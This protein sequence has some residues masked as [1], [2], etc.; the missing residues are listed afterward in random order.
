MY[1]ET[2]TSRS[3]PRETADG[4]AA[5]DARLPLLAL[6]RYQHQ[7]GRDMRSAAQA[8]RPVLQGDVQVSPVDLWRAEVRELE[9]A[10]RSV[11]H[12]GPDEMEAFQ[13]YMDGTKA[14][15]AKLN[16]ADPE[17]AGRMFAENMQAVSSLSR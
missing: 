6:L 17:T 8:R 4:Q 2:V 10:Y 3:A 1:R 9:S 14:A 13:A 12:R 5:D 16:Q 15:F 11:N 7:Q